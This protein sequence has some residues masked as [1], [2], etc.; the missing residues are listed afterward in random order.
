MYTQQDLARAAR[1]KNRRLALAFSV[2][3]LALIALVIGLTIRIEPLA[4]FGTALFSCLFYAVMEL[5]AMPYVRYAR[6]L[7]DMKAG[8][9]RATDAE[10]VSASAEPRLNGGVMFYDFIVRVGPEDGDERLF[11]YDADKP[12]P[13]LTAGQGLHITSYGNYITAIEFGG[14]P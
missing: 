5:W 13:T 1:D 3:G 4:T 6:F 9:S 2:L 7:R 8:L 14:R 12:L 10:Y 11:Y